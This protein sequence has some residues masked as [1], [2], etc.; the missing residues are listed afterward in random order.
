MRRMSC[1]AAHIDSRVR[2]ASARGV[3]RG[4]EQPRVVRLA[5]SSTRRRGWVCWSTTLLSLARLDEGRPL[6]L[7]DVD[8]T[9]LAAMRSTTRCAVESDRPITLVVPGA[10]L[11]RGG[12]NDV[13]AGAREPAGERP[14]A[15]AAGNGGR[16]ARRAT[17]TGGARIDVVD[18]GAGSTR[19]VAS[20]PSTGSGG[21]RPHA[22]RCAWRSGL[23]LAIVAAVAA[24][25]GG[26]ARLDCTDS[27][28][29]AGRI[30]SSTFRR[31][32]T[33]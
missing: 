28:V 30:S 32:P 7:S 14:R 27:H 3:L 8:L 17:P 33:A 20:G 29:L 21:A 11:G 26:T 4:A 23:G 10:G 18:D 6:E 9:V 24:A 12:R 22:G 25:H 15:H 2:R 1:D 16:G 13:A 31:T 5:R 19:A